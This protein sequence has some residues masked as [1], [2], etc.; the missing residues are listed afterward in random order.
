[1]ANPA[2]PYCPKCGLF[3]PCDHCIKTRLGVVHS[4]AGPSQ[5]LVRS[6]LK[7]AWSLGNTVPP[8]VSAT[9]DSDVDTIL[10]TLYPE[11]T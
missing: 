3:K 2:P 10:Q 9:Q 6:A 8:G 11:T 7:V 5:D 4:S 1:M